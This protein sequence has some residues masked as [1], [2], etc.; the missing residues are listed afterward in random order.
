MGEDPNQAFKGVTPL[1]T[2]AASWLGSVFSIFVHIATLQHTPL[3]SLWSHL[4]ARN[5]SQS[6][7]H[8]FPGPRI[9]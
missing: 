4:I 1:Q 7:K 9:L 3:H 8:V 2:A 6:Q 5:C